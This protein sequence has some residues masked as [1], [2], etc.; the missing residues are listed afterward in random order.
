MQLFVYSN[1]IEHLHFSFKLSDHKEHPS[2]SKP[3]S[4]RIMSMPK[5][6]KQ[7]A[8]ES[9]GKVF[10]SHNERHF[11][12]NRHRQISNGA[13]RKQAQTNKQRPFA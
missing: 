12:V 6:V 8:V 4:E 9:I 2:V 5:E 7:C 10:F 1:S 11:Y 13:L 3:F